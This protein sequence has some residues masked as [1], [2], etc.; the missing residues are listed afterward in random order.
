MAYIKEVLIQGHALDKAFLDPSSLEHS[1]YRPKLKVTD[2]DGALETRDAHYYRFKV[3]DE[4]SYYGHY[5]FNDL[6]D[7]RAEF[8]DEEFNKW[9]ETNSPIFIAANKGPM[10]FIGNNFT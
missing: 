2:G 7:P 10:I 5:A 8:D 9:Y 4:Y 6:F 3:C 1:I